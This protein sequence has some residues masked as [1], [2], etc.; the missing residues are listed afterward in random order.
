MQLADHPC[1]P[2]FTALCDMANTLENS[3]VPESLTARFDR[4]LDAFCSLLMQQCQDDA[5]EA[6]RKAQG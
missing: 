3:G 6:A 5:R 2:I 4:L 1:W